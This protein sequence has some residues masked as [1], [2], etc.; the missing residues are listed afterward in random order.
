MSWRCSWSHGP[1]QPAALVEHARWFITSGVTVLLQHYLFYDPNFPPLTELFPITL[2]VH[3]SVTL[4]WGW[5]CKYDNFLLDKE[6][7]TLK[8]IIPFSFFIPDRSETVE[9]YLFLILFPGKMRQQSVLMSMTCS[10][11]LCQSVS[12]V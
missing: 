12:T 3:T 6:Q 8:K 2:T 5:N 10:H 7:I 1:S 11:F 4:E 9:E